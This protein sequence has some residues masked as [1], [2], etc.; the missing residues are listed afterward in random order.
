MQKL[1][2]ALHTQKLRTFLENMLTALYKNK[3]ARSVA[4]VASGT[5][6]AQ[7]ITTAF[8]PLIT[9]MYG[10]EAFGILGAYTA[11]VAVLTPLAALTYPVAIVLPRED[12]DALG[13]A[14]LSLFL[15][16]LLALLSFFTL[17]LG[18]EFFVNLLKLQSLKSF[19]LLLP[20]AMLF[21]ACL[22]V[23][24][25]WCL[26]KRQFKIT[27]KSAVIHA[28]VVNG[29]KL[30]IGYF[31]PSAA[32]LIL[33]ALFGSAFH[34]AVLIFGALKS[35]ASEKLKVAHSKTPLVKIAKCY[36]EFPLYR[37]PEAFL[38][39]VT[40]GL[41]LI[42][43]AAFFEPAIAGYFALASSVLKMPSFLMGKSVGDVFYPKIVE[44]QHNGRPL[45]SLYV[46]AVSALGIL[47]IVPYGAVI[48]FGPFL[49]GIIFGAEWVVAGVFARWVSIWMLVLI[50]TEPA[51][52]LMPVL[53]K[54]RFYFVY[55]VVTTAFSAAFLVASIKLFNDP[56]I[57][58]LSYAL[59]RLVMSVFLL[60]YVLRLVKHHDEKLVYLNPIKEF[61]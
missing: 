57:T 49:F 12:R 15:A 25:Q 8:S 61:L 17:W 54:Q 56:V 34:V 38:S 40:R 53:G 18:G 32:V 23:V 55:R 60:T 51:M 16:A 5:A 29:A 58:V 47:G 41:P 30:G 1:K 46:K 50:C 13:I 22:Q 36:S 6:G 11:F 19:I 20:L 10:P 52:R 31:I 7:V 2:S 35:M 28:L 48:A 44:T 45:T 39:A 43:L 37:A 27:A 42:M 14:K 24:Q 33:I 3:F 59:I 26:R 9:R 21:S 4:I